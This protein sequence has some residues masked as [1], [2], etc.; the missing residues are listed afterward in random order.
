MKKLKNVMLLLAC[1]LVTMTMVTTSC[2]K[3]SSG[4]GGGGTPAPTITSFTPTSGLVGATVTITGTNFTG[5][6]AVKLNSVSVS[7]TVVSSTSITFTVPAGA[8]GGTI[9]VTTAGGT[10]TSTGTF[11]VSVPLSS[12]DVAASALIAHWTFDNTKAEAK[13][14]QVPTT[15][16]TVTNNATGGQIG[17]YVSFNNGYLLYPTINNLNK[18]TA[19]AGGFTFST[20]AKFA[21]TTAPTNLLTSL[22][23]INGNIGDIWGTAAFTYRHAPDSTLDFD[24]TITH[25]NGTGTHPTYADAFLEGAASGFKAPHTDWVFVT[26][27]YDTTGGSNKIKYYGNG[28][29][30]GTKTIATTVIPTTEQF[31]L[32]ATTSFG[33]TGRNNVTFGSFNYSPTPFAAGGGASASWQNTSL[34]NGTAID[35]TR[36]FNKALSQAEI[37]DLYTRGLAGN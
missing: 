2:K 12:N 28:V 7:Y 6:T 23:Q 18:D 21:Q 4:G 3:E 5:A 37:T 17:G 10:A 33:G 34:P 13:S 19:L 25:V 20:W 32:I 9:A 31:E 8:T 22:W 24:G 1:G 14:G 11:T 35:D 16:G 15:S 30:K 36:I 27:V 29:L 26:M